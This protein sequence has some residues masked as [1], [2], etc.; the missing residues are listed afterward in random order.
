[1]DNSFSNECNTCDYF[2]TWGDKTDIT[3]KNNIKFVNF[4]LLNRKYFKNQKLDKFLILLRSS[5]YN[6][7]PYDRYSEGL[8]QLDLTVKLCK[9]FS[10]ELIQNTIIRAHHGSKNRI[11]EQ[12]K[13]LKEFKL[14][15]SEQNYFEA[16]NNAK[17]VLFNHDSTGMLEM[18]AS[19]KPTLCMWARGNDHLNNFVVEDYELLKKAKILF[20]DH[21]KLYDHLTEVWNDPLRW[22]YSDS[23]QKNL[24]KFIN[25][26][27]RIPD[28]NFKSNFKKLIKDR[29]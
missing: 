21:E 17:L 13:D 28:S 20:D 10:P 12:I 4:K 27:T 16:I 25:L 18:F 7:I 15:Y 22:W 24:Q 19:N 6:A 29:L 1:M 3:K 23:V 5:G 2:I 26:Y 11:D 9:K 8:S 14:D